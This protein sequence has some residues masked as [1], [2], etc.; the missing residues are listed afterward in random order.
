MVGVSLLLLG[1]GSSIHMFDLWICF[2][3]RISFG[4]ADGSQLDGILKFLSISLHHRSIMFEAEVARYLP[5]WTRSIWA[6][7]RQGGCKIFQVYT[8]R[9]PVSLCCEF[10][11]R[12][13]G[14]REGE[15]DNGKAAADEPG[16]EQVFTTACVASGS[17]MI[18]RDIVL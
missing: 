18:R 4:R 17:E 10:G 15:R 7:T 1:F 2:L 8:T 3:S 16:Y 14:Q 11:Q 12:L 5:P 9:D 6:R 13:Q